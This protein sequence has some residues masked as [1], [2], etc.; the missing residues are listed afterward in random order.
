MEKPNYWIE[1]L[2]KCKS[3]PIAAAAFNSEAFN[4][5]VFFFA[6][7]TTLIN[8]KYYNQGDLAPPQLSVITKLRISSGDSRRCTTH[9]WLCMALF[10]SSWVAIFASLFT[11]LKVQAGNSFNWGVF[12]SHIG[13]VRLI[14]LLSGLIWSKIDWEK[15][16]YV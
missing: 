4:W 11:W 13:L 15:F 2:L 3:W 10:A 1:L 5:G 7:Q 8:K 16:W 6:N 12:D 9:S 14:L